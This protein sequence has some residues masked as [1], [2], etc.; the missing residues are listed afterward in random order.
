MAQKKMTSLKL[1]EKEG[2]K[3]NTIKTKVMHKQSHVLSKWFNAEKSE[4]LAQQPCERRR[5][6]G[7]GEGL[8]R[9][10][11]E[12][13][14]VK[15]SAT[16]FSRQCTAAC[17]VARTRDARQ[18]TYYVPTRPSASLHGGG[19]RNLPPSALLGT[20]C[21]N[22]LTTTHICCGLNACLSRRPARGLAVNSRAGDSA[23][24]I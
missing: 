16:R 13:G 14:G 18:L 1:L 9:A 21:Y 15:Q 2:R 7:W 23:A 11:A 10:G 4:K 5:Q 24:S 19:R 3:V 17:R 12:R 6:E 22:I 8:C 20:G